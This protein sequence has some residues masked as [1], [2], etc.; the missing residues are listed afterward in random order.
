VARRICVGGIEDRPFEEAVVHGQAV[1]DDSFAKP[2][3]IHIR[4]S[5]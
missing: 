5:V 1:F 3:A 2:S 4:I